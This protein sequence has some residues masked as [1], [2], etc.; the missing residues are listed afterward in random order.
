MLVELRAPLKKGHNSNTNLLQTPHLKRKNIFFASPEKEGLSVEEVS[1]VPTVPDRP[2][3]QSPPASS[4]SNKEEGG[5]EEGGKEEGGSGK[6]VFKRP[7][8]RRRSSEGVLDASTKK[9]GGEGEG[10]TRSPRSR[11]GSGS[12]SAVKNSSLLSFGDEEEDT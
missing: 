8:K 3:H 1:D 12:S 7:V 6:L 10:K 5:K 11:K 4:S 9:T 2:R